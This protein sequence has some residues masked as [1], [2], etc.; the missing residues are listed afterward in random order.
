MMLL[1]LKLPRS[2]NFISDLVREHAEQYSSA[3]LIVACNHIPGSSYSTN[4]EATT[5][6]SSSHP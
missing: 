5:I 2:F 1:I 4:Q 3:E 6:C